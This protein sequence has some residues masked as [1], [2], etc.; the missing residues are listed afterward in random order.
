MLV[1]VACHLVTCVAACMRH[2]CRDVM[3]RLKPCLAP[4]IGMGFIPSITSDG[5]RLEAIHSYLDI[6]EEGK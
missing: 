1:V 5:C 4:F 6:N 3:K 2:T